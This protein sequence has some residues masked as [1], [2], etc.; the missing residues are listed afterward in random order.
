MFQ[1]IAVHTPL[2]N[3][4]KL[5]YFWKFVPLSAIIPNPHYLFLILVSCS[6]L[7]TAANDIYTDIETLLLEI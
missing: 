5:D 2:K 3:T 1:S 7:Y 6:R 4:N